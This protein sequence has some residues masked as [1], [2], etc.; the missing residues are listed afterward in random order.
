VQ[1]YQESSGCAGFLTFIFFLVLA[2]VI[3]LHVRH[4]VET[5]GFLT[6]D[7]LKKIRDGASIESNAAPATP[8]TPAPSPAAPAAPAAPES[9]PKPAAPAPAAPS[10]MGDDAAMMDGGSGMA[11]NLSAP[12]AKEGSMAPTMMMEE[13]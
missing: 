7:I 6:G 3:G 1:Q 4:G 12:P 11:P 9:S 13:N 8:G 5:G 2:F 10:M